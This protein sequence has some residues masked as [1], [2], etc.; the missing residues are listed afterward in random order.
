MVDTNPA[1]SVSTLNVSGLTVR[2]ERDR[3][4][5]SKN[6]TQL[7]I[8]YKKSTLNT[9]AYRLKVNRWRKIYNA[10]SNQK[11]V[12]VGLL[13]SDKADFKLRKVYQG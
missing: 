13:V 2:I 10:N 6:M 11:K 1:I 3:Q 5:G 8:V 12:G 7:C 4:S 9:K